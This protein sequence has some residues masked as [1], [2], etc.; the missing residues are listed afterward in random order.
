MGKAYVQKLTATY[1]NTGSILCDYIEQ[2]EIPGVQKLM[3][4]KMV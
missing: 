1:L 2:D 3:Y 4:G